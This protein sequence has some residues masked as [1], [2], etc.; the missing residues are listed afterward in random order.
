MSKPNRI[1]SN[2]GTVWWQISDHVTHRED[3]PAVEWTDGDVW[4][5]WHGQ[6]MSLDK[7]LE[8]N[9]KIDEE[10]KTLLKLKYG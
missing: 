6:T 7:W 1:V 8:V 10:D 2:N 4:W 3:G 9:D 5:V